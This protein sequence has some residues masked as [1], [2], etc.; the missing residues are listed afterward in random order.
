M[1]PR[2]YLWCLEDIR[3]SPIYFISLDPGLVYL[4]ICLYQPIP[5][6]QANH[7]FL[8]GLS[9]RSHKR[10]HFLRYN[11]GRVSFKTDRQCM[12][13]IEDPFIQSHSSHFDE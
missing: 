10:W 1:Q 9:V 8:S 5:M 12:H 2:D 11:W 4:C 13:L 6:I 7:S 3:Q